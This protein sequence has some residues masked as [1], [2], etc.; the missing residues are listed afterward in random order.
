LCSRSEKLTWRHGNSSE[1]QTDR[2]SRVWRRRLYR[3]RGPFG[4]IGRGKLVRNNEPPSQ[5]ERVR[6]LRHDFSVGCPAVGDVGHKLQRRDGERRDKR[7]PCFDDPHDNASTVTVPVFQHHGNGGWK[8][9]EWNDTRGRLP[10]HRQHRA[11]QVLDLL[12][13]APTHIQIGITAA[14]TWGSA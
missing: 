4:H 11:N 8:S 10:E 6:D 3:P 13:T 12:A 5:G 7:S 14:E 2:R 1:P 9:D